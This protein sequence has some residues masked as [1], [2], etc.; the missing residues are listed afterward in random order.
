MI[1]RKS[2]VV[3]VSCDAAFRVFTE[4]TDLWWPRDHR[5]LKRPDSS[6]VL[7]AGV[8][9]LLVDRADD[10]QAP[11][12]RV[13][14]W[15][16]PRSLALAFFPGS[17]PLTPTRVDVRFVPVEG[18]TRVEIEHGRG[19]LPADRFGD[20][21]PRFERNWTLLLQRLSELCA[22]LHSP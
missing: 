10:A 20:T 16:P 7:E 5:P 19:E 8:G 12:G 18:G 17:G 14:A 2:V 15:D 4:R 6:L 9:G 11:I 13:L 22:E 1:V 21:A 3:R